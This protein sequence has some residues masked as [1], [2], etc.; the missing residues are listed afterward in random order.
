VILGAGLDTFF[1]RHP[2]VKVFELDQPGPQ[3]WKRQRLAELGVPIPTMVPANF[4]E[5]WWDA[6]VDGGFAPDQPAVVACTGVS[7]YLSREAVRALL[8]QAAKLAPGSTL[9]MS[10]GLPGELTQMTTF[11]P[12]EL[13]AMARE[14]GFPHVEHVSSTSLGERYFAGRPDGLWPS[15]YQDLLVATTG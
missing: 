8:A 11:E 5:P 2:D 1:Q 6:L 4:E 9:V 13:M 12:Q 15:S 14:A 10:F 3:A 7:M